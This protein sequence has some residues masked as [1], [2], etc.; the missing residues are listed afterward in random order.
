MDFLRPVMTRIGSNAWQFHVTRF[1]RKYTVGCEREPPQWDELELSRTTQAFV[2]DNDGTLFFCKNH[3]MHDNDFAVNDGGEEGVF[4]VEASP[5]A[6][7]DLRLTRLVPFLEI[8]KGERHPTNLFPREHPL[9][10]DQARYRRLMQAMYCPDGRT[11]AAVGDHPIL[12]A[13]RARYEGVPCCDGKHV[14][15]WW[16]RTLTPASWDRTTVFRVR[17]LDAERVEDA[18]RTQ[19][20]GI[21]LGPNAVYRQ[22]SNTAETTV[23]F[24]RICFK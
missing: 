22:L 3:N 13:L 7:Y 12:A 16:I 23:Q 21:R 17:F 19:G 15:L 6:R 10:I 11:D 18:G 9:S 4:R 14:R 8:E 5:N 24:R 20:I 2:L 1:L